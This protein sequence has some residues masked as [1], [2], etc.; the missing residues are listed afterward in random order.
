MDVFALFLLVIFIM[1]GLA[2]WLPIQ[3]GTIHVH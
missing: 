2:Q 1:L 3:T